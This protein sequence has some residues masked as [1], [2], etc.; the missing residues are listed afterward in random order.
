[1][2]GATTPH[3]NWG[4]EL[5]SSLQRFGE[6]L[7]R[8]EL[9]REKARPYFV[10][11]VRQS[12]SRPATDE[13]LADQV[14]RFCEGLERSGRCQD[15]QLRQAE[16][17]LRVYF[18]NFLDRPEWHRQPASAVLDDQGRIDTM[19]ALQ[20]L[21]A[22]LRTRHY[23]YRTECSSADWVRRFLDY[24]AQRRGALHSR[25]TSES[26]RRWADL[27]R[28]SARVGMLPTPHQGRRFS[29]RPGLRARR[30]GRQGP[31][32]GPASR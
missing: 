4:G 27:R 13:P 24:V 26:V 31:V 20:R 25:V 17:A 5:E 3:V 32:A 1:M 14:R 10:R 8:A 6:Y 29:A 21:R 2:A 7:L 9:V 30:E 22:R 28:R 18:G 23:S 12:L 19:A 16:Q 15:W 11:W